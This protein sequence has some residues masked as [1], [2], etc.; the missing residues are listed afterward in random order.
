MAL[1]G[2]YD[3]FTR[4]GKA[5]ANPVRLHLLVLLDQGERGV[6]ELTK[7]AGIRLQNTSA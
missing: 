6:E 3:Q 4:I 1:S 7:A 5:L 2:A